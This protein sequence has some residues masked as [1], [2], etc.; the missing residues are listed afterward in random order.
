MCGC[1]MFVVCDSSE[2]IHNF[3]LYTGKV[4]PVSAQEDI[5]ASGNIVLQLA[6][7]MHH[8]GNHKL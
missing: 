2:V 1:K 4:Y 3:D 6:L 5:K 7:V 8:R